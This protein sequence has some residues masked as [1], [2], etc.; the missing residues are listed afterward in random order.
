MREWRR[1]TGS[2]IGR[3]VA[4]SALPRAREP[5]RRA[6]PGAASAV[7]RGS[8]RR[9]TA[10]ATRAQHRL[11]LHRARARAAGE[12]MS[13]DR[14]EHRLH[15]LGQHHRAS[16]R[17]AP[18][19]ARRGEQHQAGARRQ[20]AARAGV[21]VGAAAGV[22]ARWPRAAPARSRAAPARRGSPAASRCQSA[23]VGGSASG[24]SSAM[25]RAAVAAGRGARARRRDRGSRARSPSGSGRAAI[26]A[27]DRRRSAR[28][29]SGWR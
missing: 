4:E 3:R 25:L 1:T 22:A 29:G 12:P 21:A 9:S 8:D 15:V 7:M 19:R 11:R 16:R 26:R 18:M 27:A 6:R 13:R 23:S 28:P 20:P 17:S 24:G 5:G 14:R 10:A 2:S